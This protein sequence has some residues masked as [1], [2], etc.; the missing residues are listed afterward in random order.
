MKEGFEQEALTARPDEE[1]APHPRAEAIESVV[2][3]VDSLTPSIE[4]AISLA[5]QVETGGTLVE[6]DPLKN[7]E[8]RSV[9]G[10]QLLRAK[11]HE[12]LLETQKRA[13]S[14]Y[15]EEY[16]GFVEEYITSTEQQARIISD[17]LA[18]KE[19]YPEVEKLVTSLRKTEKDIEELGFNH[20]SFQQKKVA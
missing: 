12:I 13:D 9:A 15:E 2:S 8:L 19:R 1:S 7:P 4:E 11:I 10:S 20:K 6:F 14:P 18:R 5:P 16:Y 3:T 17:I